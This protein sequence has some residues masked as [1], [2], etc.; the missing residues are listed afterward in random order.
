[1]CKHIQ[2]FAKIFATNTS[3]TNFDHIIAVGLDEKFA[4]HLRSE[5]QGNF[6]TR[7]TSKTFSTTILSSISHKD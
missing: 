1:M 2:N 4:A 5:F 7:L 3:D 6:L